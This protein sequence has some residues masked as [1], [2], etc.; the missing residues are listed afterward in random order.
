[1]GANAEPINVLSVQHIEGEANEISTHMEISA[2]GD[3]TRFVE[4]EYASSVGKMTLRDWQR[5]ALFPEDSVVIGDTWFYSESVAVDFDSWFIKEI[6]PSPYTVKARSELEGFSEC[7]GRRCAVINTTTV[8]KESHHFKV[9]FV[10]IAFDTKTAIEEKMFF[11]YQAGTLVAQIVA[12]DAR[13][14]SDNPKLFNLSKGQT[15]VN[16]AQLK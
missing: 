10:D 7:L 15:I 6:D 13:T 14:T 16:L 8:K 4:G 12:I 11:D 3:L 2:Q 1:M 9:F 5:T